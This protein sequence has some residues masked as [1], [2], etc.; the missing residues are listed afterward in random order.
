MHD[1]PACLV[2]FVLVADLSLCILHCHVWPLIGQ[3]ASDLAGVHLSICGQPTED[4]PA[5]VIDMHTF[6]SIYQSAH[7]LA[8]LGLSVLVLTALFQVGSQRTLPQMIFAPPLPPPKA[9]RG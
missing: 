3:R 6:R 8:S 5:T 9:P 7:L 4:T 1:V 2:I